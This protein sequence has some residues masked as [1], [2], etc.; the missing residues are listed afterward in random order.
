MLYLEVQSTFRITPTEMA[1]VVGRQVRM[2][3]SSERTGSAMM[4]WRRTPAEGADIELAG[5]VIPIPPAGYNFIR[6]SPF[7]CDM[8]LNLTESR[9]GLYT[10]E[11]F[12][13]G[14]GA[15]QPAYAHMIVLGTLFC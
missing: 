10:C 8:I 3:C 4:S 9:A 2:N 1:D 5:C 14:Q 11:P 7:G 15:E 6:S 13:V 12:G